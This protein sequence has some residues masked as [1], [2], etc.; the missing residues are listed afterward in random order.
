[1]TG[2]VAG[3]IVVVLII[4]IIVAIVSSSKNTSGGLNMSGLGVGAYVGGGGGVQ[5]G[6]FDR[7]MLKGVAARGILLQVAPTGTKSGT[8]QRRFELRAVTIDV[9][10]PGQQPYV[11]Q[12][13]PIIPMNLVR[14]V[15][16]GAT[17]EIRVDTS[18]P[19]NIAIVG[20]GAGFSPTLIGTGTALGN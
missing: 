7:L 11:V 9:E 13:M 3:L 18:D 8:V 12:C 10:V 14:D 6:N 20:P 17:L 16:P 4:L 5:G 1:M 19:T 2:P 15:L